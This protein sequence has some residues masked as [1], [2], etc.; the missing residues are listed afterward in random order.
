MNELEKAYKEAL[1][2][3]KNF[4]A[5]SL[6]RNMDFPNNTKE[7]G[8]YNL[9]VYLD[10]YNKIVL[11]DFN[12]T[13]KG[14]Y[15]LVANIL[16]CLTSIKSYLNRKKR[17]IEH[18]NII[19]IYKNDLQNIFLKYWKGKRENTSLDKIITLRDKFEHEKISG[20]SIQT[21]FFKNSV[22]KKIMIDN[23]DFN[24]L[25]VK[26]YKEIDNLDKEI[27]NYIEKQLINLNLR[28]NILLLNAF[29]RYFKKKQYSYLIP[30]ETAEE[31]AQYDNIILSFIKN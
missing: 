13:P 31:K 8:L 2:K 18:R 5:L 6:C 27:N 23:I 15:I 20:I 28:H 4:R 1:I 22:V 17:D 12:Y 16:N 7:I 9:Q 25:L 24:D 11:S 26:A 30:D 29:H 3:A 14:D 19:G 10:Y 21:Y